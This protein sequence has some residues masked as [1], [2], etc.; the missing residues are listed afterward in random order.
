MKKMNAVTLSCT[1]THNRHTF[2]HLDLKSSAWTRKSAVFTTSELVVVVD[3]PVVVVSCS[4]GLPL[5]SPEVRLACYRYLSLSLSLTNAHAQSAL[6]LPLLGLALSRSNLPFFFFLLHTLPLP[7]SSSSSSKAFRTS[8]LR[9]SGRAGSAAGWDGPPSHTSHTHTLGGGRWRL[10][11]RG[12]SH[13]SGHGNGT[14]RGRGGGRV[15]Y[16]CCAW[17]YSALSS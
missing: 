7:S 3:L 14:A 12:M 10:R 2:A 8:T 5:R 4:Y 9:R 13:G 11:R 17:Q 1:R 16:L 15:A 6:L